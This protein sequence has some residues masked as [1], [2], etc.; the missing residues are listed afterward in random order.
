[1][2]LRFHSIK[3][4]K[5]LGLGSSLDDSVLG[6]LDEDICMNLSVSWFS[7]NIICTI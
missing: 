6:V 7:G 5:D 1:M 2:H 4:Y 3:M